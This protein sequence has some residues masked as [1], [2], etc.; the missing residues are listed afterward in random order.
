VDLIV[1]AYKW[2]W[3]QED[4]NYPPPRFQGRAMSMEGIREMKD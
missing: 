4:M 1:K 2:I 3:V